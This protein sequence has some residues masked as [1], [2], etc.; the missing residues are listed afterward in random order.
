MVVDGEK[1]SRMSTCASGL[2]TIMH[3]TVHFSGQRQPMSSVR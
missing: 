2:R 3:S 1:M